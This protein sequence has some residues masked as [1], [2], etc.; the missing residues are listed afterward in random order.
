MRLRILLTLAVALF[1]SVGVATAAANRAPNPS[2][3][4]CV[5]DGGTY[6][7]KASTSFFAPVFT[8]HLLWTCNGYS[9]GST[10]SKA[11]GGSCTTDGGQPE[12]IDSGFVTCWKTPAH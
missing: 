11:L 5:S 9:G 7:T 2:Q 12:S 8:K 3:Q 4:L 6:S 10:A 1:L